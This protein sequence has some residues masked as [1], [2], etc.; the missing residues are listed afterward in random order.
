MGLRRAAVSGAIRRRMTTENHPKLAWHC[1]GGHQSRYD[2][3]LAFL[4]VTESWLLGMSFLG[5]IDYGSNCI[6]GDGSLTAL[7]Y[8]SLLVLLPSVTALAC[9]RDA[10]GEDVLGR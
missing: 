6:N 5:S 8:C 1:E 4:V 2:T 9:V 10:S 3:L 7:I